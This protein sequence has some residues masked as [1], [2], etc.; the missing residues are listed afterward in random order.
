MAIKGEHI[1]ILEDV[2]I[3]GDK[4]NGLQVVPRKGGGRQTAPQV[5]S[6]APVAEALPD[7]EQKI[8]YTPVDAKAVSEAVTNNKTG[9][10]GT[11]S[12]PE[13]AKQEEQVSAIAP[14]AEAVTEADEPS[15]QAAVAPAVETR[16][17]KIKRLIE[18]LRG[19]DAPN[20]KVDAAREL[21]AIGK[22][23]KKSL[24]KLGVN[25]ADV[26]L[27]NQ[28]AQQEAAAKTVAQAKTPKPQESKKAPVKA[29]APAP[30]PVPTKTSGNTP[31]PT[32]S[33]TRSQKAMR[34]FNAKDWVG[35]YAHKKAVKVGFSNMGFSAEQLAVIL[36]NDPSKK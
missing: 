21:I 16:A 3:G 31:M 13:V 15:T 27:V 19:K 8:G 20:T 14:I 17:D 36:K 6:D 24:S 25:D 4:G 5:T 28:W 33:E 30:A 9:A 23:A 18:V 29:A 12:A 10:P 7:P 32:G 11:M 34:L 1:G 22:G 2:I 26:N 35:L